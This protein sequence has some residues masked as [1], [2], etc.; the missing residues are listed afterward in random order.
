MIKPEDAYIQY[1]CREKPDDQRVFFIRVGSV[2][3]PDKGMITVGRDTPGWLETDDLSPSAIWEQLSLIGFA[4]EAQ[5]R[6]KTEFGRIE[7][8]VLPR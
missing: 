5:E 2:P 3:L 6:A 7:G 8:F 1:Q 4:P